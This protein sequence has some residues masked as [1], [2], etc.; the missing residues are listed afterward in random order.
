[1]TKIQDVVN[2]MLEQYR[3]YGIS[4][5]S[6]ESYRNSYCNSIIQFCDRN[7][8]GFY[9]S[10]VLDDYLTFYKTRLERSEIGATYY[11]I[12]ARMIRLLKAVG[13]NGIADFSSIHTQIKYDPTQEHWKIADEII[14]I[15][16]VSH[17][18]V[19]NLHTQIRHIFCFLE[20]NSI[21]DTDVT[22]DDFF[23]Y[24]SFVSE[25]NKGSRSE[26]MRAVRSVSSYLKDHGAMKLKTDYSLLPFKKAPIH[27]IEPYSPEEIKKIVEAIDI[28]SPMGIR[29]LA[30]M[31]LE[32]D[33]GSRGV[34]I[35]HLCQ[36]DIDRRGATLSIRQKKQA[37]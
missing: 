12:I 15:N 21:S 14:E 35:I 3:I 4:K 34:D 22:D 24:L 7:N 2:S 6:I 20:D 37:I 17:G 19:K 11:S 13:E 1:M 5:N 8:D 16:N 31:L 26:T 10:E 32:C 18:S 33:T 27:M 23:K 28:D 36:Q 29:D 25:S 30:I 9:A